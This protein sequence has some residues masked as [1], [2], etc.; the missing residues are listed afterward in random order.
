LPH[1]SGIDVCRELRLRTRV[2]IIMVTAKSSEIDTVVGLEVGADDYVTKP[3]RLRELVARM[4]A[5]LRRSPTADNGEPVGEVLEVGG[6]RLDPARHEV[7]LHGDQV[8]LPL[9]EFELLELLMGNAGR[10]LTR[11]TLIDRI[12]GPH[13]V[14]DTKTL[15]VHVK[16]LRAKIE[17][18]PGR[19]AR[20]TTI[21]GLGYKFE[22]L[23]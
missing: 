8:P 16:R 9:K 22:A 6:L 23:R 10:V 7:H 15:D 4:R 5:V 17:D 13:Y 21:R 20:I 12:W 11:E 14:G 18:D 19:P 3:Y 1:K 2:P